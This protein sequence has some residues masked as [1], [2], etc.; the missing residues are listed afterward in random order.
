M[1]RE[2]KIKNLIAYK[3]KKCFHI[4]SIEEIEES[5]QN[6]KS[7]KDKKKRA[8]RM[9][10][11]VPPPADFNKTIIKKFGS[12]IKCMKAITKEV[13]EKITKRLGINTEHKIK[14]TNF[15]IDL[16]DEDERVCYEIALGNGTEIF[17]DVLK[18]ILIGAKKLVIF[19]RSYPNPWGMIGYGYIQRHWEVMKNKIKLDV[20][21]IEFVSGKSYQ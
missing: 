11:R 5:I 15:K 9:A 4:M 12:R 1:S 19:S 21:I 14:G 16:F 2:Q 13:Q 10:S 3:L 6:Y 7:V 17:K 18:A 20:E 8:R